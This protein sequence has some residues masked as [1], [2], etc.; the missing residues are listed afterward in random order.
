MRTIAEKII[1]FNTQLHYHN[2]L[3]KGFA[4]VNPFIENPETVKVMEQFYKKFYNDQHKRKFIIGIN[5]GR[6]GAGITGIPFTDTKRLESFCDIKMLSAHSHEPSSIFVYD[7]IEK[8]GG[9]TKFYKDFYIN[10]LFPLAIVK[11][12]ATK[13]LVNANYYDDD[14]LFEMLRPY[15]INNL[16]KQVAIGINTN[17]VFVLGKKNSFFLDKINK[18]EKLFGKLVTLEHPRFIQQYKSK[19]KET[20]IDKYLQL[21][22]SF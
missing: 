21:L 4:V 1:E 19:Q 9:T 16:K 15:I 10:S 8:Y 5:P 7:V 2:K 17:T 20:Y 13:K 6:H 22:N 11:Q 12:T 18:E 3:P 14:V